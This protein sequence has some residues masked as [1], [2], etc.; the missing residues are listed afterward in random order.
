MKKYIKGMPPRE[1][2]DRRWL[3]DHNEKQVKELI[4]RSGILDAVGIV[5]DMT[6]TYG[7]QLAMARMAQL[8]GL[9]EEEAKEK[10]RQAIEYFKSENRFP[11]HIEVMTWDEA[12]SFLPM[13]SPNARQNL[14]QVKLMIEPGQHLVVAIG[15]TGNTYSIVEVPVKLVGKDSVPDGQ[16]DLGNE[17]FEDGGQT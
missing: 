15:R 17:S 3:L 12:E 7:R 6:G 9:T 4:L 16:T 13:T 1:K 5:A 10:V 8:K 11:T 14:K 2:K